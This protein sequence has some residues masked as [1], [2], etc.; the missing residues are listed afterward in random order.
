MKKNP[1]KKEKYIETPEKM[2]EYF[3]K[4]SEDTKARPIKV[5]DWV[6]AKAVEVVREKERPLTMEGFS[7]WLWEHDI[8]GNV[9]DYFSN[10]GN[11]YTSYSYICRAIREA[12]RRDQIEGGMAGIYNPSITQRLNGLVEKSSVTVSEQPLFPDVPPESKE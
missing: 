12:I 6:G 11:A 8:T 5:T 4:Y 10:K 3:I 9:H 2:K 1:P 7:I